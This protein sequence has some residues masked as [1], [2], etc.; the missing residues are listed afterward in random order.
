MSVSFCLCI[1]FFSFHLQ[2]IHLLYQFLFLTERI[3]KAKNRYSADE[4]EKTAGNR[5]RQERW[6]YLHCQ[7]VPAGSHQTLPPLNITQ[8]AP[9]TPI[10]NLVIKLDKEAIAPFHSLFLFLLQ[11]NLYYPPDAIHKRHTDPLS[12]PDQKCGHNQRA[13]M[14]VTFSIRTTGSNSNVNSPIIYSFFFL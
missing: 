2:I 12:C 8:I 6:L 9:P 1:L 10:A 5:P 4:S 7:A 13:G 11:H 3:G 14:L